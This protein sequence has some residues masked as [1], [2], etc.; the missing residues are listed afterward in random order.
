MKSVTDFVMTSDRSDELLRVYRDGLLEDVVPFWMKHALDVEH[1]GV[2]SCLDR[3]GSILDTD[4]SVWVQGRFAW[5]MATLVNTVDRN[6]EW[7]EATHRTL[8]FIERCCYDTDSRMFFRVTQRGEPLRKRR[9]AYSEA[10]AGMAHAAYAKAVG[11][12]QSAD[13]ART[14]FQHFVDWNFTPGRMPPKDTPTR[15]TMG[16]APWMIT[17]CMAQVLR[18]TIAD[19]TTKGWINRAIDQIQRHF[20]KPDLQAVME[21]VGRNGE[22]ID[23]VDGRT[24]CPGHA[25]ECAWF[26]L[27]EAAVCGN[28]T[29][30]IQ[31]GCEILDYMWV[32][33]WDR[34]YGGL[35]Y[36][37]DL[38]DKPV[39]GEYWH[40]MK[41]WWPH[42]EAI[43]ATL[44]AYQLTGDEKYAR[45]HQQVHDW[46]YAHF[47]DHVHGEWYG[48]L[49]RDG[50]ISHQAK[51]TMWKGPLHL[52]RMQLVCWKL[53]EEMKES[54][55]LHVSGS[56]KRAK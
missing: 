30:L 37:V 14:L 31:L 10:F 46:S 7:L 18:E 6:P 44:M 2:F 40:D 48:Y 29:S 39:I 24:L 9:Y 5:M 32:R 53:L 26:I 51:G 36:F 19:A 47:P 23:H 11:C 8:E 3:D 25:I 12:E 45:W 35:L 22:V 34:E 55:P 1:G 33:G 15:P 38:Y 27:Q 21:T 43:I 56:Q 28:D 13:R 20:V 54:Q 49:H 17:I 50:R 42:N 16:L 41:F 4:K 52:P